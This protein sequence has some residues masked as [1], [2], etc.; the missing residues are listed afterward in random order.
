MQNLRNLIVTAV[1]LLFF[2]FPLYSENILNIYIDADRSGAKE[3]GFA[4]EKGIRL[5]LSE[6]D[7]KIGDHEIK[8]LIRDHHGNTRRSSIHINEFIEDPDALAMFCGLHSP[9]VLSNL[10]LIQNNDVLL[11]DPWAAAGPITR[12]PGRDKDNWIF[13][14]S[15]DDNVAG[16]HI[17]S[18]ACDIERYRK[19]VLLLEDTGWG[20]SNEITIKKA[21]SKRN[22][23]PVDIIWFDWSIGTT[24]AKEIIQD[25]IKSGADVV[26]LVANASEG[27]SFIRAMGERKT[28]DR[29]PIRS[30]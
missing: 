6:I 29:I 10:E 12:T 22:I 9:P 23:S 11:L 13:R 4:I 15:V 21:L 26:F 16:K 28:G 19:P 1:F 8:L 17:V 25:I 24:G 7:Y 18:Y 20:R 27:K 14:L 30:H 2:S 3:S 5:A